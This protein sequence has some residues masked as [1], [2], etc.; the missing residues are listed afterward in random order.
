MSWSEVTCGRSAAERSRRSCRRQL[1]HLGLDLRAV[2]LDEVAGGRDLAHLQAV[3]RAA[4]AQVDRAADLRLGLRAAAARER[5][6]VRLVGGGGGV[7]ERDRG[8]HERRVGVAHGCT[9]PCS[10]SRSSQPVSTSPAR[11]S[12]RPRSSSRKPWLVAP[13]SITTI[14]S[15]TARRR[16]AMASSRVLPLAM[17]LAIIES[18]S[19]GTLSPSATPLSTRMPGPAGE[20]Q[21]RD[22]AGRRG[23]PHARVLGVEAYLDGVAARR[24]R[25]ALQ[26]PAG[27]DMELEL[28]EVGA[29][30]RLGDGMLDL[31]PRVDLHE[32]EA[33][34]RGLVEELDRARAAIADRIREPHGGGREL[35]LLLG[36]SAGL[37]DSSTTFW[38]RRW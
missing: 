15:A 24:R 8:L 2:D 37:A 36:V 3:A 27:G 12:G 29:G 31:Q 5:V 21:Q 9:S 10:C 33:L 4:V 18:N 35:G 6:Q 7:A 20:P 23:E 25:V 14:V 16:R 17:I 22:P 13:S 11:S 32:R 26:A 38:W 30:D 34:A 28:H 19:G 1:L